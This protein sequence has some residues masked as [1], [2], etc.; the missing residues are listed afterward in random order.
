[1]KQFSYIV[2]LFIVIGVNCFSQTTPAIDSLRNV[3]RLAKTD[4][5]TIW[6]LHNLSFEYQ[7]SNADSSMRYAQMGLA[8]S[9]KVAYT[10][11]EI[12][13]L[14]DVGN[15]L[16]NTGNFSE[17]LQVQFD[18]LQKAELIKDLK[19]QGI[20]LGNIGE[21]Y[22]D[23]GDYRQAIKYAYRS[24]TIDL[25]LRDTL[26]IMYNYI[27]LGNYF[28]KSNAPDSALLYESQAYQ[29]NLKINRT[30]LMEAILF[31]LGNIQARLGNDDIALPYFNKSIS[32]DELTADN[33]Q[34]S[35]TFFSMAQLYL[36]AGKSDSA[37]VY[38]KNAYGAGEKASSP[39][40]M[41]NASTLL[42]SLYKKNNNDSTLKY[43]E[44]SVAIKDSIFSQ[45][46]IKQVQS[47]TFAEQMRQ[48]EIEAQKVIAEE[49]R[50]ISIQYA[51]IAAGIIIFIILF[52]ILSRSI[53]VNEKW[54]S[55][56]G[57]LG[58]LVIFEFI[59]LFI[60]PSLASVT[61][62]SPVL[63]LLALVAIASLLIPLHHRLEKWI[64]EKMVE[65]NKKIRLEAAK[66]TIAKLSDAS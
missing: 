42:A 53:I 14:N 43:L 40:G 46:K 60:H 51:A 10:R 48:Q 61:R 56:F 38:L 45:E 49:Q 58:L 28:E 65:K 32:L 4:S 7:Y 5:A 31:E 6:T 18:A 44:L 50:K 59:N 25:A 39:A 54:I 11:G 35:R 26:Y 62:D 15:V 20:C 24:N 41:L 52:F 13:C 34:L 3:L 55:F 8:L 23:Q 9:K 66:K 47:L 36:R 27:N 12:R 57:V 19:M 64:K 21:T 17:A 37:I 33:A 2:L 1:M 63:M 30:D 16:G 29:L 22:S